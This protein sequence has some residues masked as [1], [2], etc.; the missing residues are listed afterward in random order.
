MQVCNFH[1]FDIKS[2][3]KK[4]RKI[5][6]LVKTILA[7]KKISDYAINYI[8]CSDE[9]LLKINKEYLNHDSLTDIITFNLSEKGADTL[10]SDIYISIERVG[11]NA[12]DFL[13]SREDELLRVMIHGVL[14]LVGYKDK[15]K[16]EKTLMRRME[17]K[18][19]NYYVRDILP[20]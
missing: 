13:V 4:K 1:D 20:K 12:R 16:N 5:K 15:T 9:H 14:H 10:T 2:G 8:F 11:E 19:M 6:T 3:L 18:W 7:K 17:T